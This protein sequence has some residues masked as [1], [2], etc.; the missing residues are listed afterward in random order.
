[1]WICLSDTFLSIVHKDC[2]ANELTVRAR[3]KGDIERLFPCAEVRE[4][5]G[6][7]YPYRAVVSRKTV[8]A[9]LTQVVRDIDYGNF[10]SSVR[11]GQLHDAY[12]SVWH[13]MSR[14]EHVPAQ[15]RQQ[16]LF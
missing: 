9:A 4:G 8:A 7:D 5:G 10:K 11:D 1:M 16:P 6:T 3:R 12:Y 2:K 13:A 15:G 14:I